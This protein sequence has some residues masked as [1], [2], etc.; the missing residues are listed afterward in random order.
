MNDMGNSLRLNNS[1][2]YNMY[3]FNRIQILTFTTSEMP[4]H[5]N[6]R[7]LVSSLIYKRLMR[8]PGNM[9]SYMTCTGLGSEA[10]GLFSCQNI[11]GIAEFES[12][13]GPYSLM[14]STQRKLSK[15]VV[16]WLWHD[17]DWRLM[18]CPLVLPKTSSEHSLLMTWQS[19]SVD[20]P[21][22]P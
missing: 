12:E 14:N 13:S 19:V 18:S 9:V 5:G 1:R 11:S 7:Q 6:S 3:T 21:W 16:S 2:H 8:Q 20:A 22:T 10:D 4:Y 15:L 17:L